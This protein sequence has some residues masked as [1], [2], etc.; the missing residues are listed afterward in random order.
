[1]QYYSL[2]ISKIVTI[3]RWFRKCLVKY[4]SKMEK[5]IKQKLK[6]RAFLQK[7]NQSKKA[8]MQ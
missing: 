4:N 6:Q 1:M 3:Q 8:E 7:M 2:F 5:L